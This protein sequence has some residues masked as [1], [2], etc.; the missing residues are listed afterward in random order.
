MKT[1]LRSSPRNRAFISLIPKP[2]KYPSLIDNWRLITLLNIDYKLISLVYAKILKK[3]IDTIINETQT[4]FMKGCHISSNIRL[5]LDLI[6]YSDAIGSDAVVL[7]LDFCKAFDTIEHEFLFRSLKLFG[8][9]EH[10]IKVIRMFYKDIN[11]SVLLNLNTSKRFSIN[12]SVQ[13]GCPISPF[14]FILVVELF[15]FYLF[16]LYLTR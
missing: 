16:H 7:F 14:L 3:E 2:E 9:G 10:F 15:L 5:V 12:R 13:Q 6:D 11:S 4:G 1:P 8:F